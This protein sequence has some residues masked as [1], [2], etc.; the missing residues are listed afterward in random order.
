MID[1]L[2]DNLFTQK[3]TRR[4]SGKI[5]SIIKHNLMF[6]ITPIVFQTMYVLLLF[7]KYGF[8]C[9]QM[10]NLVQTTVGLALCW[11]NFSKSSQIEPLFLYS[12]CLG[13]IRSNAKFQVS[14]FNIVKWQ[15]LFVNKS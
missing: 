8:L 10:I 4:L 1:V 15:P 6:T 11:A 9:D 7:L 3:G 14:S 2:K 12:M 13:K 5:C